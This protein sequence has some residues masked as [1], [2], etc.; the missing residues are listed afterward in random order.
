VTTFLEAPFQPM[1]FESV[2]GPIRNELS[3]LVA[4]G[5]LESFWLYRRARPLSHSL[6][7][8]PDRW[9]ALIRGWFLA[10]LLG[11]VD[12][13]SDRPVRVYFEGEW[14]EFPFPMLGPK[15][16][17]TDE[18]LAAILESLPLA[19]LGPVRGG[20]LDAYR[21]L[22]DIGESKGSAK[23][24]SSVAPPVLE[25]WLSIGRRPEGAP[26]AEELYGP[27]DRS[28]RISFARA[29]VAK[30][31]DHFAKLDAQSL[32]PDELVTASRS[33]EIRTDIALALQDID[34]LL[35]RSTGAVIGAGEVG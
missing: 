22:I 13:S 20:P 15:V 1:V 34:G 18:M 17:R 9:R 6:P 35:E 16:V 26:I 14:S 12:L 24:S 11:L 32:K 7:V 2:T 29:W 23:Y 25:E 19:L 4:Q 21:A 28:E 33:W 30:F 8:S 31:A 27:A 5:D 3:A 10:R